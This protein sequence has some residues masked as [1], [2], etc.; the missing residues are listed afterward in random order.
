MVST[1]KLVVLNNALEWYHSLDE[2]V[3]K[4]VA[5]PRIGIFKV[6]PLVNNFGLLLG[7]YRYRIGNGKTLKLR[8]EVESIETSTREALVG[9]TDKLSSAM[10]LSEGVLRRASNRTLVKTFVSMMNAPEPFLYSDA[11]ILNREITVTVAPDGKAYCVDGHAALIVLRKL[12]VKVA[13]VTFVPIQL[14]ND[15]LKHL[16]PGQEVSTAIVEE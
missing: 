12:G 8:E 4:G 16:M 2:E 5:V 1:D 6:D 15:R 7:P 9:L 13:K 10:G 3:R 11:I 14:F